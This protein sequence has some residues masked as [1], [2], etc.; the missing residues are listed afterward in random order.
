MFAHGK[1]LYPLPRFWTGGYDSATKVTATAVAE[2]KNDEEIEAELIEA[3][4]SLRLLQL[5]TLKY[6]TVVVIFKVQASCV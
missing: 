1:L 3:K 2:D 4:E 5:Q 6:S